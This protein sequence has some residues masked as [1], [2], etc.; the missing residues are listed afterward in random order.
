MALSI[1]VSYYLL[2]R[3]KGWMVWVYG[4]QL[5]LA[6]TT[7]LLTASRGGTLAGLVALAI[8]PWTHARLRGCQRIAVRLTVSLLLPGAVLSAPWRSWEGLST[9]SADLEAG[10][11]TGRTVV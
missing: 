9:Y 3:S 8:V 10:P 6:G 2:I 5:V 7:I 11:C 4:L 1:P